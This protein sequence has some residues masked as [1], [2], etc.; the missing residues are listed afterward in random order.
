MI[1]RD[2]TPQTQR[3][4]DIVL[5]NKTFAW[6]MYPAGKGTNRSPG[7]SRGRCARYSER[8]SQSLVNGDPKPLVFYLDGSDTNTADALEGSVHQSLADFQM[9][10]RDS[11]VE[12]L[13]GEVFEM[14]EKLPVEVRKSFVSLMEPWTIQRQVLYNPKTRFIDYVVP[15]LSLAHSPIADGDADGLHDRARAR[16][17]NA[18]SIAGHI[19]AAGEIVIGKIVPY[20]WFHR[21]DRD[22]HRSEPLAVRGR[23]FSHPTALGDD[24]PALSA[25]LV[26]PGPAHFGD[27]RA[28]K[29]RRSSSRFSF[30]CRS[31][32]CP[33]ALHRSI[34]CRNSIRYISEIFPLTHFC[35]AFRLV[36]MYHAAP[37]VLRRRSLVLLAGAIIT[38]VGAAILLRRIEE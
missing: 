5:K 21:P 37:P 34:N 26:R 35:R 17:G 13:P 10:E 11:T 16:I 28:P 29:P 8:L 31:L 14:G 2:A 32:F 1:N 38:F 4:L 25:L 27:L 19:V 36:N 30:C 20:L 24:L 23:G 18:L 15:G 3:F 6:Q 33:G 12:N 22:D 7:S 9:K